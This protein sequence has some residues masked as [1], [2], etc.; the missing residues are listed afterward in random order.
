MNT[1]IGDLRLGLRQLRTQPG[2]SA[3]VMVTLALAEIP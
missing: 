1:F 2:H 3:V